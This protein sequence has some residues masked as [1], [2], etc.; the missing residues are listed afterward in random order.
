MIP[1][2]L[3]EYALLAHTE[4]KL[5]LQ[6]H[7]SQRLNTNLQERK[8][9]IRFGLFPNLT[10]ILPFLVEYIKS[11]HHNKCNPKCSIAI[12]TDFH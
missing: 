1:L 2:S 12:P 11:V 8:Q 4:A 7:K 5:S 6:T 3:S 9:K 10:K